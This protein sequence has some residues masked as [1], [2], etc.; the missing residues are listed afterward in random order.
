MLF[1]LWILSKTQEETLFHKKVAP[2]I[3]TSPP[4]KS[5]GTVVKLEE[6]VAEKSQISSPSTRESEKVR[7]LTF[8][9]CLLKV[10]TH[11]QQTY[12]V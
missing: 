8:T 4:E 3:K 1:L 2:V 5:N 7:G 10:T 9:Y 6:E 12:W 11:C